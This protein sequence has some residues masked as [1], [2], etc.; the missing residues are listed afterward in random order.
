MLADLVTRGYIEQR[1]LLYYPSPNAQTLSASMFIVGLMA[2]AKAR[3][4][5]DSWYYWI[6]KK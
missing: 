5:E 4:I 3:V 2:E 6:H 1:V